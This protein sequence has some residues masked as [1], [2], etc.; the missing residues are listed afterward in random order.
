[1]KNIILSIYETLLKRYGNPDWWPAETPFEVIVGAVLTQN[2][3][4][5]N[6]EKAIANFDDKLSPESILIMDT[7]ELIEKIRPAGFFKQ[8]AVYLK[9]VTEWFAKYNFNVSAIKKEPLHKIRT[10]LL[11]VKGIGYET[12]DSILLYAF[13]FPS[14][15][16]DA[17]TMRMCDRIPITIGTEYQSVKAYFE[18]HLPENVKIYNNYHALIV[19]NGKEH[20]K[21][22][23]L[24][25]NCPLYDICGRKFEI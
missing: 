13:G 24:C 17:Y 12:A 3:A 9:N 1:M 6:V 14:F 19:I 8:K 21:K 15:V 4:W 11:A 18:N 23:P 7:A 20:C 5:S 16:V 25:D 2:C 10:E 22:K